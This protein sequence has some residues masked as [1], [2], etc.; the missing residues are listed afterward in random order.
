MFIHAAEV[1]DDG[2][3]LEANIRVMGLQVSPM[4]SQSFI[5]K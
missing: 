2:Q 3:P 1:G 4:F 5:K